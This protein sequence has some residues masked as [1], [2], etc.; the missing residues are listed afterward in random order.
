M[1]LWLPPSFETSTSALDYLERRV[2]FV[3]TLSDGEIA[4]LRSHGSNAFPE[5]LEYFSQT[6]DGVFLKVKNLI[7]LKMED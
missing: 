2:R 4:I 6:L 5:P 3:R 1:S 7:Q